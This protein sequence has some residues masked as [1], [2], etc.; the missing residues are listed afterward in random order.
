M[1][2]PKIKNTTRY[3]KNSS[4]MDISI[5][6]KDRAA[7]LISNSLWSKGDMARDHELLSSFSHFP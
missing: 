2:I 4:L 3:K 6:S 7:I 5:F 1:K